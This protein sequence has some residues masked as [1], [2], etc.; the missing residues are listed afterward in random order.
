MEVKL[1]TGYPFYALVTKRPGGKRNITA[2]GSKT[3]ATG[4]QEELRILYYSD[5]N[6]PVTRLYISRFFSRSLALPDCSVLH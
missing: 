5:T 6:V 2:T 1:P 4:G 3:L